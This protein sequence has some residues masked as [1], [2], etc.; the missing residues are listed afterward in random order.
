MRCR[1][2][3]STA[4]CLV[5]TLLFTSSAWAYFQPSVNLGYTSFMDGAPPAGPGF[6]VAEYLSYYTANSWRTTLASPIPASMSG[7]T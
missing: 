4:T 2:C 6:Y 7:P 3:V 1:F 5:L